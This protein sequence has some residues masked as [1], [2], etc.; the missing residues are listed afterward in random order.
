VV[1]AFRV[2]PR[3]PFARGQRCGIGVLAAPGGAVRAACPGRVTFAGQLPRQG[4]AVT[5]RCGPLVATYLRLDR[6]DVRPGT[7]VRRGERLGALGRV[8]RLRLGARR[9]GDRRGYLDPLM[10]LRDPATTAPPLLGP[11]PRGRRSRPRAMLP[12]PRF[13][14]PDPRPHAHRLPWPAY[15]AVALIAAALPVGGLLQRRHRR[16]VGRPARRHRPASGAL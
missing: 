15:P 5:V 8:G 11:A 10:L 14:T 4:L 7:R 13:A 9:A 1:G 16:A 6:L 3:A 12:P 2:T